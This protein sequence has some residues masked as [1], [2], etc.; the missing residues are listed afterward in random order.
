MRLFLNIFFKKKVI[1]KFYVVIFISVSSFSQV[2]LSADGPGETYELISTVL[3]NE[4]RNA[5]E[6]PDC[7]HKGFG[8]HIL[9]VFDQE[10]NK[11]VFEFVIHINGDFDRCKRF[12][13]Q[14]NEIKAHKKSNDII[15]A[16]EG[17]TLNYKWKFKLD[18]D[19]KV[20]SKYTDVHQITYNKTSGNE[21]LFGFIARDR[22]GKKNFEIVHID[23]DVK[24]ILSTI[25][26]SK[27]V[28]K[29]ILADETITYA[30]KG[31]YKLT[32]KDL[33]GKTLLE[34]E[35]NNIQTWYDTMIY[36]RPKWGIY[37]SLRKKE[38]LRD[39][40]LY[41]ADFEINNISKK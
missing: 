7:N 19:F 39:E 16:T 30:R 38:M 29:W 35:K 2:K 8:R 13:R 26:L 34:V 12:D 40:K 18:K 11:Y 33:K 24:K 31:V 14:R 25:K 17:E 4:N 37:R 22:K 27:I 3:I 15:L 36:A 28:G 21:P 10:L 32:L 9:E 41:F 1:T 6:V 23:E 20:S 5:V